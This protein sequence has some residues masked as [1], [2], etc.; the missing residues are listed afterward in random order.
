MTGLP[1]EV[2]VNDGHIREAMQR[3]INTIVE[4]IKDAV[5][6]TPPELVADLM[7]RGIILAGGGSLLRG[8]DSLIQESTDIP[9]RVVDDPLTSVVRGCGIILEDIDNLREIL[10]N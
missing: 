8:L 10:I 6:E 3:S 5:E 1:K 7:Q 9:T 4:T 2:I